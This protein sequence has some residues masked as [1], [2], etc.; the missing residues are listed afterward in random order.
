[1]N[2]GDWP[3]LFHNLKKA[4]QRWAM[5]P[6][7]GLFYVRLWCSWHCCVTRCETW[8]VSKERERERV[9]PVL[10]SDVHVQLSG[11]CVD[12]HFP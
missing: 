12:P 9:V 8:V 11:F 5:T 2:N 7:R 6:C 4:Q 10:H 1:M 3:A